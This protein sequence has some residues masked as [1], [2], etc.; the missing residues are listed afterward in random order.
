M[1]PSVNVIASRLPS[2]R[3]NRACVLAALLAVVPGAFAQQPLAKP[4]IQQQMTPEQF[5]AAGL[6][7]L[8]REELANL[9][10]WLNGTIDA[11]VTKA[12]AI[13]KKQVEEENRGFFNFGSTDP[14]VARIS[15]DFRGFGSHRSYTLDNRQVW[16]QID[17]ATL[18]GVRMSNPEVKITPS[19]VGNAWYLQVKGYNTRAKVQRVK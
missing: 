10:A 15:G 5:K 13:S 11:E 18:A 3:L 16:Q 7:Q 2:P 9:N 17:A 6:H 1:H 8:N 14:I 19:L 4:P 12:R